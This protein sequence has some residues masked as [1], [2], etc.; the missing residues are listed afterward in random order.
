MK[1]L[2]KKF[3]FAF[4]IIAFLLVSCM[5]LQSVNADSSKKNF[6]LVL[7]PGHGCTQSGATR[8]YDGVEIKECDLNLKIAYYLKNFLEKY[9]TS[10]G[11]KV[12]VYLTH[13]DDRTSPLILS[14]RVKKGTSLNAE[15]IISLHNNTTGTDKR[16]SGAMVLVTHSHYKP[17]NCRFEDLYKIEKHLGTSI[18]S[19]LKD[20]G[21]EHAHLTDGSTSTDEVHTCP[22]YI[23]KNGFLRRLSND[24]STYKN[25]DT[26]D[27]YGIVYH[28]IRLGIP[29]IIVEHVYLDNPDDYYKY[30]SSDEKLCKLAKADARGI[31]NYYGLVKCK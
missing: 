29:S 10:D 16:F 5:P 26:T 25:G 23:Y 17:K 21:I 30:L 6:I 24:G 31:I 12:K 14:E 13:N 22:N 19:S 11:R 15:A 3:I 20:I 28:G 9:E 7:D 2:I 8:T 18:L 27:W 1:S 4:Q